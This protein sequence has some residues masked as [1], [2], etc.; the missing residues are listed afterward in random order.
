MPHPEQSIRRKSTP[1]TGWLHSRVEP[2]LEAAV[3]RVASKEGIS[4]SELLR[5]EISRVVQADDDGGPGPFRPA[6]G[7][8][9]EPEQAEAA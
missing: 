1:K 4:V 2:D 9:P 6:R 7:R 8:R 3:A 5:R